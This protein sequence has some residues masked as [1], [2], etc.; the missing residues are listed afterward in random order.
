MIF[1]PQVG[2]WYWFLDYQEM[3]DK[4]YPDAAIW[5][6]NSHDREMLEKQVV[7]PDEFTAQLVCNRRNE[8][9]QYIK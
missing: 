5:E 4:F 1:Q 3:D 9:I 6:N 2:D 8:A 7:F